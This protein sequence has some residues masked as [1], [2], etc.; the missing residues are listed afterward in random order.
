MESKEL[1]VLNHFK[2][3]KD[4]AEVKAHSNPITVSSKFTPLSNLSNSLRR[5]SWGARRKSEIVP[6]PPTLKLKQMHQQQTSDDKENQIDLH[7]IDEGQSST[8]TPNLSKKQSIYKQSAQG[9]PSNKGK[10]YFI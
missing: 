4:K 8:A 1:S 10:V 3:H 7:V 6:L 9:I 2:E 5:L